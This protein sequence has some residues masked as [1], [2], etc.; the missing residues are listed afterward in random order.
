MCPFQSQA[1]WN[2]MSLSTDMSHVH[3]L[4]TPEV[5][6]LMLAEAERLP[7]KHIKGESSFPFFLCP[8][9]LILKFYLIVLCSE[10]SSQ[11]QHLLLCLAVQ[12]HLKGNSANH[13][14]HFFIAFIQFFA[15][16]SAAHKDTYLLTVLC[17]TLWKSPH[18]MHPFPGCQWLHMSVKSWNRL[19]R[20][21]QDVG[22]RNLSQNSRSLQLKSSWEKKLIKNKHL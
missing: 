14:Y 10:L 6:F 9:F 11:H 3:H 12:T 18:P 13:Q 8:W 19:K 21:S 4:G 17:L 16:A 22:K 20:V 5:S 2:P 1:Q 15:C 7:K